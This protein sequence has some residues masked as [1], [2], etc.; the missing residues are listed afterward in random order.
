MVKKI[1]I[2]LFV[3]F[4]VIASSVSAHIINKDNL[5]DDIKYSES[6]DDIV[7]LSGLG[8]ISV[9]NMEKSSIALRIY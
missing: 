4:S 1:A 9:I 7:L 6:A 2:V 8:I 5:Y 3:L